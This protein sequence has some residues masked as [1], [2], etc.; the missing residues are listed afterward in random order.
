M[1]RIG[2]SLYGLKPDPA[3]ETPIALRPAMRLYSTIAS[4]RKLS[5]G[6]TV[7]YGPPIHVKKTKK[8]LPYQLDM[9][10]VCLAHF[11]AKAAFY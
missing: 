2:I 8:S 5:K 1:V 6:A 11:Q 9:Q 4:I 10:T 3:L 7:S